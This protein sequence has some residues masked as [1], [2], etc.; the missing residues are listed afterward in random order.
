MFHHIRGILVHTGPTFAVVETGGVG[1]QLTIP[2]STHRELPPVGKECKLLTHFA[3]SENAQS[4]YGFATERERALFRILISV[5][6]VGAATA[7]Q[8]LSG[9]DPEQFAL[10]VERQ[11]HEF[12]KKIKGI[13]EKTAK[14]ITLE[15][16]GMAALAV[17]SSATGVDLP[18]SARDVS[19]AARQALETLGV[20]PREAASRVEKVLQAEPKLSLEDTIRAALQ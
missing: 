18:A 2:F 20:A 13:G 10:A 4:L 17:S 12:L 5:K 8:I 7:I 11:D 15:L 3:V 9:S 16:K 6:G 1:Y 14:R 19:A